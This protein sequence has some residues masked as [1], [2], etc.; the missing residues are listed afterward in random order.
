[1]RV[2]FW[3][4]SAALFATGV[5]AEENLRPKERPVVRAPIEPQLQGPSRP[6]MATKRS[7]A[8]SEEELI[9][10]DKQISACWM[11]LKTAPL[12]KVG[13]SLDREGRPVAGSFKE[14]DHA[15]GG[16]AAVASAFATAKRAIWLCGVD[17]YTLPILKY[18]EWRDV[19]VTFDPE[20]VVNR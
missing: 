5:Q 9:V 15:E 18:D 13:F 16:E 1:M 17:G 3:F 14:V 6:M 8:L 2:F 12:V 10:F 7:A 19:V 11:P 20:K 4:I